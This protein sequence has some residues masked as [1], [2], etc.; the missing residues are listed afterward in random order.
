M[1]YIQNCSH[2][3]PGEMPSEV[4][5]NLWYASVR[6]PF[7]L[8]YYILFNPLFFTNSVLFGVELQQAIP[9]NLS[10]VPHDVGLEYLLMETQSVYFL[11]E[12]SVRP[13]LINSLFLVRGRV[14]FLPLPG[15]KKRKN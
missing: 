9:H 1:S 5:T 4:R 6:N 3:K 2:L 12:L 10:W 13:S 14:G 8:V 15:G 7:R 11:L